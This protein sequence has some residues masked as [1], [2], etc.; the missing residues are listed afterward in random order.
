MESAQNWE[1][2]DA[3]APESDPRRFYVNVC[4]KLLQQGEGQGCPED[5]A[6]CAIGT[7]ATVTGTGTV[8]VTGTTTGPGTANGTGTGTSDM[9]TGSAW[10]DR[11]WSE[12]H[13]LLACLN[14][15]ML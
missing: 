14:L 5:A 11:Y 8:T 12:S 3:N 13:S 2:V 9:C 4:H 15:S 6:I 1:A 10:S 7:S